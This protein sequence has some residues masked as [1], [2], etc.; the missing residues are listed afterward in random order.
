MEISQFGTVKAL[1]VQTIPLSKALVFKCSK[2]WSCK[3]VNA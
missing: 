1:K 3:I 2:T